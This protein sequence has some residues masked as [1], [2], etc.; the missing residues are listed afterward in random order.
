VFP[1]DQEGQLDCEEAMLA[2]FTGD[3]AEASARL[4][5]AR[6]RMAASE[7]LA[8]RTTY[9][10]AR[11]HVSLAAGDLEAARREA[12]EGVALEPLGINSPHS[13]AIQARACLWL[14]DVEGAREALSA[15]GGFR[16][17]WMAAQR[18]TTEAGLAAL[19][20]RVEESAETYRKAIEAWRALDSTLD[21]ALCELDL[22]VLLGP[23][24]PD[25][26]VAK[27]A[28]D[29]FSELGARPFLERLNRAAGLEQGA[30]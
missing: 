9:L 12:A 30:K 18:L 6:E 21:L 7:F 26:T 14:R 27:E 25:A 22:V 20:E 23:D 3:V 17:R 24:H 13:L 4:E 11:S 8:A 5:E 10:S 19:E 29:I 28:R 2:A 15:M 16:G 1:S